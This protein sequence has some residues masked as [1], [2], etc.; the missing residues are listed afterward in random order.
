MSEQEL[1]VF[2][3]VTKNPLASQQELATQLN[4]SRESVAGHIMRL[5][6]KGKILGKGY[7]LAQ[8]NTLVVI[9]GCNLDI[10]G[11][12]NRT[13]L[14]A[15]SNPG[16]IS[17]SAGGVGRNIA[18]NLVRLGND[19]SLISALG[20]DK[21]GDW[22][23]EHCRAAGIDMNHVVR[24]PNFNTG[25]YVAINQPNGEL[26]TAIADM[27]ILDSIDSTLLSNKQ[28]LLSSCETLLIEANINP[29]CIDWLSANK[30][31]AKLYADAVSATKAV[32]LE[33]ILSHLTGLKAN[34][35]EAKAL[36]KVPQTTHISNEDIVSKLLDKGI[37]NILLSLG[38]EGVLFANQT[39]QI[40]QGI[41]PV[42]ASSDTGAGDAL[43][44]AFIHGQLSE[45]DIKETLAFA[46][47]CAAMTLTHETANNPDIST[48]NI[49]NW[50][51]KQ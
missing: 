28:A 9:G 25:T 21:S 43:F 11:C 12:S 4:M 31:N 45:W 37:A 51:K 6:R 16:I 14:A 35:E 47:A 33:P 32:R 29:S 13:L 22:L 46:C 27:A 41:Y 8:K 40:K 24:K 48:I 7:V 50:M 34:R 19:V 38:D 39:E 23:L 5:T 42:K 10:T 2:D 36:L 44:S 18:E 20:L 26:H 3:A 30:M 1:R 15:D 17:Q 49:K